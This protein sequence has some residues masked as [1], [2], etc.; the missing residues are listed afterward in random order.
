MPDET[1]LNIWPSSPSCGSALIAPIVFLIG[2]V[3]LVEREQD[4]RL[5]PE[6][7]EELARDNTRRLYMGSWLWR[8]LLL[9][10]VF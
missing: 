4:L 9:P 2:A 8:L 6:Q 5:T 7:R 10:H 1:A 3:E